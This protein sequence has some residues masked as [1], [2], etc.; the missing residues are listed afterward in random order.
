MLLRCQSFAVS[1]MVFVAVVGSECDCFRSF[2][3]PD[4][5][6][7]VEVIIAVRMLN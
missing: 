5:Q 4:G 6:M 3:G 7:D 1:G 2:N